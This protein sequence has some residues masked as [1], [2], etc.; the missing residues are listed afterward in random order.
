MIG[1][2][3]LIEMLSKHGAIINGH[4]VYASGR[5]GS[6]YINKDAIYAHT[7]AVAK[8][9]M[10]IAMHFNG[11]DIDVVLAPAVGGVILSQWVAYYASLIFGYEVLSVYADKETIPFYKN[12]TDAPVIWPSGTLCADGQTTGIEVQPGETLC[13]DTGNFVIKRGYGEIVA[14]GK[15]VLVVEDVLTTGASVTKTVQ[16]VRAIG[17]EVVAVAALCNRGK[18]TAEDIGNVPEL[19]SLFDLP[20]KTYEANACPLCAAGVPVDTSAGKGKAFLAQQGK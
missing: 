11:K 17:G 15:K 8:L 14:D 19:F 6:V 9:S 12:E 7:A 3:P 20:L 4:F 2:E 5:H 13:R 10:Y 1:Q 18:V 16:A